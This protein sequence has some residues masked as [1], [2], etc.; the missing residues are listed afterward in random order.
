[1]NECYEVNKKETEIKK[2]WKEMILDGAFSLAN[3]SGEDHV[4]FPDVSKHIYLNF[5]NKSSKYKYS[6]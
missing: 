3:P 6:A 1:M 2:Q 4:I 5:C